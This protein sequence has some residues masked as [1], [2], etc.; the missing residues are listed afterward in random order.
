MASVIDSLVDQAVRLV[1]SVELNDDG[2][3][4]TAGLALMTACEERSAADESFAFTIFREMVID[5]KWDA[6]LDWANAEGSDFADFV[7]CLIG[8][9]EPLKQLVIDRVPDYEAKLRHRE[10]L[11]TA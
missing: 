5:R 7:C 2:A 6:E 10:Q 1:N 11:A 3:A 8:Y 4:M 9:C